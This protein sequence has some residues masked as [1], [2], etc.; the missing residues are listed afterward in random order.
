MQCPHSEI[1]P[2]VKNGTVKL[3]DQSLQQ[4]YL[5]QACGKRFNE[6]TENPMLRL[7]TSAA[8]VAAAINVWT[9][10]LGVR[11]TGHSFG[12]THAT[13]AYLI[14]R[15]SLKQGM[16]TDKRTFFCSLI[17]CSIKSY[18]FEPCINDYLLSQCLLLLISI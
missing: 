1:P 4:R 10:G 8:V 2:T 14:N 13:V 15:P 7:K 16:T 17:V 9:E 3:Q 6:R 11:A 12:K 5:Y 18:T